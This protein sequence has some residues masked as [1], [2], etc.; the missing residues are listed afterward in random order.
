[1]TSRLAA[2]GLVDWYPIAEHLSRFRTILVLDNRG[3]GESKS[4][5]E[6]AQLTIA[7]HVQDVSQLVTEAGW[8]EVDLLGF[9]MGGLIVQAVLCATGLPFKVR[10]AILASTSAQIVSQLGDPIPAE[11][12]PLFNPSPDA[13]E[14]VTVARSLIQGDYDPAFLV[15][16]TNQSLLERRA[17]EYGNVTRPGG[18]VR[19]QLKMARSLSYVQDLQHVPRGI[20]ILSWHGTLDE[21]L[22]T[23]HQSPILTSIKHARGLTFPCGH[24]WFDYFGPGHWVDVIGGFLDA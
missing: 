10:K 5:D 1:M 7:Q 21:T 6:E 23:T 22:P 17:V 11:W 16:P 12:E 24:S 13:A 15:D 19:E 8:V 14:R 2:S 4:V 20:P 18:V 3:I 9:S